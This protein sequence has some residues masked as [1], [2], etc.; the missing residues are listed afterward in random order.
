M[1]E[2]DEM[3]TPCAWILLLLPVAGA[4]HAADLP[5]RIRVP[6][7]DSPPAAPVWSGWHVGAHLGILYGEPD[8][9]VGFLAE[10]LCRPDTNTAIFPGPSGHFTSGFAGVQAGYDWQRDSLVYGLEADASIVGG[11][12]SRPYHL[13]AASLTA[14]GLGAITDPDDGFIADFRTGIDWMGT[15]RGRIGVA[16]GNWLFYATGGLAFADVQRTLTFNALVAPPP[17][18]FPVTSKHD[19]VDL[20]WTIGAGVE[21]L[22]TRNISAKLEY[23]YTDLGSRT[24]QHGLYINDPANLRQSVFTREELRFHTVKLGLN[25]RFPDR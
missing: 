24:L 13:P 23:G 3:R 11:S 12:H 25:L 19:S 8:T 7:P 9:T 5:S 14:A 17:T 10:C 21:T 6:P 1:I 15:A 20:G 4:V 16:A 18:V 22:L 2:V